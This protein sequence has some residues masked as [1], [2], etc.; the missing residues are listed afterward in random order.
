MGNAVAKDMHID[1]LLSNL[2][3]GYR[4]EG[5]IA[6]M[7]APVVPVQKQSDL[8]TIFSRAD[9]LRIEDTIRTPGKEANII[10][11]T[12]SSDTFYC[13]NYA[14]QYPV[15]IE[16]K[17]NADAIFVQKIINGR[18]MYIKDKLALDWEN[19]I[20]SKVNS[21]SNVGSSSAVSS[22]WVDYTEGNSDPEGDINTAIVDV[23]NRTGKRPNRI[24]IGDAAYQNLRRHKGI[25]NRIYGNNNGGGYANVNN[26]RELFE[27]EQILIGGAF[28]N[29][30]NEAQSEVL[31]RIWTDNVL[32]YYAPP[33]P[34]MEVPS[35]MYSFRWSAA[36]IPNMQVER[37][38]YDTKKKMESIEE[39]YYQD[40]KLTGT[41][42]SY[43][44]V[45][46]N[47]PT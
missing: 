28:K 19:R 36:G 17:A 24:V 32:V 14:L 31:T 9:I 34:A 40:E 6:D 16:D 33:R 3:I 15:T 44:I 45:A 43:L 37:H 2:A 20:A 26:L 8:Y 1:V 18:V 21:T 25:T 7:I 30:G 5:M 11:Q 47:S 42:Y 12:P 29:T 13:N 22:A 46:V 35:Y 10:G 4:P 27:V 39:G 41:E 23:Q 38:A